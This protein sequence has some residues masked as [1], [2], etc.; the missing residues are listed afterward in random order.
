MVQQVLAALLHACEQGLAQHHPEWLGHCKVLIEADGAAAY[1][2]S[3]GA[4]EPVSW[5]GTLHMPVSQATIT[6]YGVVYAVPDEVVAAVVRD[7]IRGK[8]PAAHPAPL[9]DQEQSGTLE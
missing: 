6:V 7:A 3:T 9:P 2:S 1:G 4:G 8:L 5:R